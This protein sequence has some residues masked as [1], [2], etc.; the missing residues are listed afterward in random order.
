MRATP[1]GAKFIQKAV[2]INPAILNFVTKVAML[3]IISNDSFL[4]N[5]NLSE[6]PKGISW[7][8][9]LFIHD[10]ILLVFRGSNN[11]NNCLIYKNDSWKE[12]S[13]LNENRTHTSVVS[14]INVT[15]IIGG[16]SSA[17]FDFLPRNSNV[18]QNNLIELFHKVLLN[19]S[20][21]TFDSFE[22]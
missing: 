20:L 6:L 1:K 17:N 19:V 21:T 16:S 12:H 3:E 14:T 5:K 8:P 18:W 15:F 11:K 4:A 2:N 9:S 22:N 7:N 13:T 10:N